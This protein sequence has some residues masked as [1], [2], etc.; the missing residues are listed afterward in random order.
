[1]R[2]L[3]LA[4]ALIPAAAFAQSATERATA[5]VLPMIQEI[6]PGDAGV[7]LTGCII[8]AASSD[9]I[10]TLAAA[11]GPSAEI[12]GLINGILTRPAVMQCL[13]AAAN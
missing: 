2:R 5:T 12:G 3:V 10:A 8:G 9:E 7:I 1:M 11:P 13:Q 4:L 6:Q